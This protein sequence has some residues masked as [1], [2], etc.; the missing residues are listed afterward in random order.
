MARTSLRTHR[1]GALTR[2][3]A[4]DTVRLGGWVHR[5]RD[6]GG[7]VF[8][9][10]RDR[11]GLVQLSCDPQWTPA[12][13]LARA[14]GLGPET[15]V[16]VEGVVALRTD[17][18]R[19]ATMRSHEVEVQV[20]AIEIVGPAA[21]PAI[22]VARREGEELSSEEL[23]LQ[24]RILDLRRP[25][26][27]ANLML[28]HRLAQQARRTLSDLGFLEIETPILTKPTPEGARDYLVPSRV[29]PG[30]C[31]AL[32]QSPQIYKQLLMVAGYDRYFQLAR[33]F[34][35][36]DLRADRQPEFTQ[37]DLEASFVD[38]DDVMAVV[39]TVLADLWS[40]AGHT[41]TVP[42]VRLSWKEA[43]ERY[44]IDKPDL[45]FGFEIEDWSAFVDLDAAPFVQDA[46][47]AGARLRGIVAPRQGGASRKEID[48]LGESVRAAGAGGLL[49]ARRTD[50]G[51]EGQ[52]VKAFGATALSRIS[53]ATGDLVL[54]VVGPDA[55]THP[56]LHTV[57]TALTRRPGVEP[58]QAHAFA[59][60]VDFPLFEHDPA[61]GEWIFTHHP[62]TSPHPD[63]RP[64]LDSDPGRCRAL[65]YDAVYNGNEL[66][67]GSIRITDPAL[68]SRVFEF[69]G[70]APEEQQRRF[71]FLLD[72][73]ASGAPPHGGFALGFDRIVMLLAGVSSLRDVIAFPK[74][75]QARALLE[76]AP[77]PVPTAD[78]AAL[79]LTVTNR[80]PA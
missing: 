13:V 66:G 15:V 25:E 58:M 53:A 72:A 8:L 68:Q 28:R 26:L 54:G 33:C 29:H 19:D 71:G 40:E 44:G 37:I 38:A 43:M 70:L 61:T 4:G 63:D 17:P 62:F 49:W 47:A 23:R 52:G 76:G 14:A 27:Q 10:L 3:E 65:H 39:E 73:L 1:A 56:A 5:R 51:W 55:V 9:D 45:R 50:D 35:D 18:A 59:W 67:S 24:H 46:I 32:P 74:T 16:L 11:D 79:H 36:E 42:F 34:R 20:T 21:T 12:E 22:P 69:L 30:E 48:Q 6:L 64:F 41:V 75:A 80:S 57:R 78:L 77:V 7:I 60:V 2:A 31:Y